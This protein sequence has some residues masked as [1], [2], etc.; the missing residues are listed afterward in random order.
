[1]KRLIT[2]LFVASSLLS[3]VPAH[4][5]GGEDYMSIEERWWSERKPVYC[6]FGTISSR[7]YSKASSVRFHCLLET[8]TAR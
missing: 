3:A 4:A 7:Y 1:M 6:A 8:K 2:A 5:G